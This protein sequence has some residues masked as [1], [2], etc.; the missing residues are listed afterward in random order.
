M[1]SDVIIDASMKTLEVRYSGQMM[2]LDGQYKD[3]GLPFQID[4][5]QGFIRE[6][7]DFCKNCVKS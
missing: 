7:I 4:A 6:I 2:C 3:T 5:M 1:P